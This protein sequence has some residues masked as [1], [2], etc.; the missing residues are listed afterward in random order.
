MW[1]VDAHCT[2]LVVAV[3]LH[4][5]AALRR[6]RRARLRAR[7]P[8]L[9]VQHAVLEIDESLHAERLRWWRWH[10]NADGLG[11]DCREIRA[12]C[13]VAGASPCPPACVRLHHAP[14][15]AL[16]PGP[17]HGQGEHASEGCRV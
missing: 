10:D 2:V 4:F 11:E 12:V 8:P 9:D 6:Q 13:P 15:L 5:V 16:V 3:V 1:H 7:H 17:N 14:V